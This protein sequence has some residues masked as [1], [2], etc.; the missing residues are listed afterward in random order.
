M[1]FPE[2][3]LCQHVFFFPLIWMNPFLKVTISPFVTF[4]LSILTNIISFALGHKQW[5]CYDQ[6]ACI[7]YC[8]FPLCC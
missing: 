7:L 2:H 6:N 8:Y 3:D 4:K 1:L 5:V